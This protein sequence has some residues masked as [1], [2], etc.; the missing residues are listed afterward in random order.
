MTTLYY[1]SIQQRMKKYDQQR[2]QDLLNQLTQKEKITALNNQEIYN[3]KVIENMTKVYVKMIDKIPE[4]TKRKQ[5]E[6]TLENSLTLN[7]LVYLKSKPKLL[8]SGDDNIIKVSDVST[9]TTDPYLSLNDEAIAVLTVPQ[10][11]KIITE[12]GIDYD[13]DISYYINEA[14][15]IS[16]GQQNRASKLPTELFLKEVLQNYRNQIESQQ[17][18]TEKTATARNINEPVKIEEKKPQTEGSGFRFRK[19]R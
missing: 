18:S 11:K 8:T 4:S 1:G 3:E 19:R 7:E 13:A 6:K 17:Q 5:L 16:E 10:M 14:K 2:Q 9:N 15:K 12:F